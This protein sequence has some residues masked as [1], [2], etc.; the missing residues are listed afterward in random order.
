HITGGGF[1][2]NIPRMLPDGVKAVVKK[3]SYEVPAIFKLLQ[4]TGSIEEHMMYNTYNMGLGMVLAVDPAD[5]DKTI[6]ALA[7]T[8]DTAYVV[9][10]I[11]AGDKGVELI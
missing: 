2:E 3:D 11:E 6:A 1:Y 9:G 8:G 4:K 10:Q 5:V 7:G